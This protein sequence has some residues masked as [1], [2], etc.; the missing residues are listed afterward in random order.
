MAPILGP[1]RFRL[2]DLTYESLTLQTIAQNQLLLDICILH[3]GPHSYG[4]FPTA[5][6]LWAWCLLHFGVSNQSINSFLDAW[7]CVTISKIV[8]NLSKLYSIKYFGYACYACLRPCNSTKLDSLSTHYVFIGC[9]LNHQGYQCLDPRNDRVCSSSRLSKRYKA[10]LVA[11]D[12][13]QTT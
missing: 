12:C 11:K 13:H 2:V 5:Q 3:Y 10:H 6:P 9:S 4:T 1:Y 8:Q 7:E